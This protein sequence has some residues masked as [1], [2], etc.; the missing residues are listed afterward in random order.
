MQQ[1]LF[2]YIHFTH[3]NAVARFFPLHKLGRYLIHILLIQRRA[4]EIRNLNRIAKHFIAQALSVEK[5]TCFIF[6]RLKFTNNSCSQRFFYYVVAL[7]L[8]VHTNF[9]LCGDKIRHFLLLIKNVD[10]FEKV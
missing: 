1:P 6:G 2:L 5:A 3:R 4:A 7:Y 8:Y 10:F 9:L